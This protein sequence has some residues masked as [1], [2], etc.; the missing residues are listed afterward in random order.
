VDRF[1]EHS[2]IYAFE[3][4]GDARVYT[5]SADLMP[6]NLYNRV[7]LLVPV[8]DPRVRAELLDVLEISL[9]ENTNAWTL[10]EDGR[11]T[12]RSPGGAEPRNAQRELINQHLARA[13]ESL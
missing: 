8:Q 7:E 9:A 11:W 5:G 4:D 1:L 3:R 12:R 2:R 6:R 13:S 10:G